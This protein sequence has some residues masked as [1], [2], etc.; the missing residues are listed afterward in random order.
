M[1][2]RMRPPGLGRVTVTRAVR[3]SRST[4]GLIV[5]MRPVKV[6]PGNAA[7]EMLAPRPAASSPTSL[8][9]TW[10]S[11]LIGSRST[12]VRSSSPTLTSCPSTTL[13]EAA[14]PP[15]G[16]VTRVRSS[17]IWASRSAISPSSSP[18]LARA[19]RS[20][21]ARTSASSIWSS[22]SVSSRKVACAFA[23]PA[24]ARATDRTYSVVSI[25]IRTCPPRT[26]SL[27][28]TRSRVTRPSTWARSGAWRAAAACAAAET[29]MTSVSRTTSA[30]STGIAMAVE[31]V[32]A[33]ETLS[34]PPSG[35]SATE[36]PPSVSSSP[37]IR[38]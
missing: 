30:P 18:L 8:S 19:T 28:S 7:N 13:S 6:S 35:T 15:N 24:R 29:E 14:R 33:D 25:S 10:A 1:P 9:S 27:S 20:R 11:T 16:A 2:G 23:S 4:T 12:T 26:R 38:M 32:L 37:C 34:A 21:S 36:E 5:A 17:C 3:V 31:K 22:N